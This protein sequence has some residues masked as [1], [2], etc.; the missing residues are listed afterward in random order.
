MRGNAFCLE[1]VNCIGSSFFVVSE[2]VD[3]FDATFFSNAVPSST[4]ISI[5]SS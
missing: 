1:A 4:V 5:G 2:M 3:K